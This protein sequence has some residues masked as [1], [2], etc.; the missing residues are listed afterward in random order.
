M[1]FRFSREDYS[2][3]LPRNVGQ[4]TV[5]Q[6]SGVKK[7]WGCHQTIIFKNDDFP[8]HFC[9]VRCS[10]S[11]HA[12]IQLFHKTNHQ[13]LRKGQVFKHFPWIISGRLSVFNPTPHLSLPWYLECPYRAL[14]SSSC[15]THLLTSLYLIVPSLSLWVDLYSHLN[16]ISWRNREKSLM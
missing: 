16:G 11:G 8:S 5:L 10:K 13:F 2:K 7:L 15:K 3:L 9:C 6:W 1:L 12:L 4:R 14:S